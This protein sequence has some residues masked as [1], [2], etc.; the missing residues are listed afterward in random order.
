M[1]PTS[2]PVPRLSSAPSDVFTVHTI[3]SRSP[4][5]PLLSAL[6]EKDE[7]PPRPLLGD[8]IATTSPQH[9]QRPAARKQQGSAST[10]CHPAR[11][12]HVL[13]LFPVLFPPSGCEVGQSKRAN[14][15]GRERTRAKDAAAIFASSSPLFCSVYCLHRLHHRQPLTTSPAC[16]SDQGEGRAATS[17]ASGRCNR[18]HIATTSAPIDQQP[19]TTG[20]RHDGLP[21][22]PPRPLPSFRW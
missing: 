9:R 3:A 8:V 18:H 6:R 15:T 14:E 7:R 11:L 17:S 13:V 22:S 10:V 19:A 2:S 1:P 20:Q 21:S 4:L 5:R 12:V 16:V